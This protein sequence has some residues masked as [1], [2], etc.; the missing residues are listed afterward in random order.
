MGGLLFLGLL[1]V[2]VG[3]L[4]KS[5]VAVPRQV[6]HRL[7]VHAAV[8]QGRD[9]VVAEGVEMVFLWETDGL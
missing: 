2:A 3:A 8:E 6:G 7:L 9:E 1:G 5:G 4:Q